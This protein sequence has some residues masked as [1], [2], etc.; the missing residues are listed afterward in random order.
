MKW[1]YE[2]LYSRFRA[3][4]DIGPRVELVELVESGRIAPCRAIDLGSGTGWNCIFLAQRGFDVTGVDFAAGAIEL[5]RRR[6]AE[7][8]VEVMFVE[9]DLTDLR[10]I[11]GKFDFLVDFGTLD[12]LTSEDRDL[13]LQ[14]VVPLTRPGGRFY[15]WCFEWPARRWESTSR[16]CSWSPVRQSAA[17]ASGSRLNASREPWS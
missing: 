14:N 13:Y 11:T 8:G 3:P 6:A 4:C 1:F 9:D 16:R 7:A 15:L 17:L 2:I 12:D 5:G 10:H